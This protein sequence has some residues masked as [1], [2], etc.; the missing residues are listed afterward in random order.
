[1][2][3]VSERADDGTT[4]I[5]LPNTETGVTSD[6]FGILLG[7]ERLRFPFLNELNDFF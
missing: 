2:P 6:P 3:A 5:R 4:S 1:M 7:E